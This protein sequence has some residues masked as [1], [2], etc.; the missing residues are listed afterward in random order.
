[1]A[2]NIKDPE[3]DELV[4]R[5]SALTNE[6]ITTAINIAVRERLDRH[7]RVQRRRGSRD[8]LQR[9]VDEARCTPVRDIS[10]DEILGY[11][12]RGVPS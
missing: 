11:D 3:T 4:R 10:E 6:S 1:M 8:R 5:L 12:E 2:I 7:E 9:I